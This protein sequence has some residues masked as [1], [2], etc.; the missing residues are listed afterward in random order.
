[1]SGAGS[2]HSWLRSPRYLRAGVD[3]LVG[4]TEVQALLGPL[5]APWWAELGP[6]A[7]AAAPGCPRSSA[8]ALMCGTDP[9][10]SGGQ[11]CIQWHL[12]AQAIIRQTGYWWMGLG[13]C[14]ASY[15]T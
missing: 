13:L 8:C 10:H 15:L 12:W 9:R 4:G 2:W 14:L 6:G 3:L 7:L 11:G 1:M 5:A